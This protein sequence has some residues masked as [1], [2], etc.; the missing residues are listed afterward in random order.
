MSRK[1]DLYKVLDVDKEASD[2][3]I[4][5][6]YRKKARTTHPDQGGSED[7][8]IEVNK[9]Y[10]VLIDPKKRT[11]YD[12]RGFVEDDL[13]MTTKMAVSFITQQVSS[14]LDRPDI[15][16]LDMFEALHRITNQAL[17]DGVFARQRLLK[18][19]KQYKKI[20]SKIKN[21][22]ENDF[23]E[24]VIRKAIESISSSVE[25]TLMFEKVYRLV[26]VLLKD[27]SFEVEQNSTCTFEIKLSNL[28]IEDIFDSGSHTIENTD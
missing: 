18:K 5:K 10:L 15:L 11:E 17:K 28:T 4:K 9:A 26:E 3:E 12:T 7:E 22:G 21:K 16:F 24:N 2:S 19:E 13:D 27:Y 14:L 23:V 8:F 25:Q 6:A 20:L 1:K